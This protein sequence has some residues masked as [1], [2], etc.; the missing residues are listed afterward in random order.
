MQS[1][2][3]T[4]RDAL[5]R[6]GLTEYVRTASELTPVYLAKPWIAKSETTKADKGET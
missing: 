6:K 1:A 5:L 2:V 4:R 3:A